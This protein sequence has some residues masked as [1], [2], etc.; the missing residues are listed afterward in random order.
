LNY[1]FVN[2][3]VLDRKKME[4]SIILVSIS[5]AA[6]EGA[7]GSAGAVGGGGGEAGGGMKIPIV[8]KF[9]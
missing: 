5:G 1:N 8:K 7:G 3:L 2:D 6:A 4:N 9:A